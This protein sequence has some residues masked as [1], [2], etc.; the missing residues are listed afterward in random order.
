M[1]NDLVRKLKPIPDGSDM[2]LD[3]EKTAAQFLEIRKTLNIEQKTLALEMGVSQGYLCD[4]EQ[5]KRRWSLLIFNSAKA[6][7]ERL[8]K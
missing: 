4:L 6:A 7:L 8:T 3:N 5:G 1:P 2:L